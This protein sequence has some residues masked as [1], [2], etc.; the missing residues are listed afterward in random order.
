MT[1]A[2][3][4]EIDERYAKQCRR[5]YLTSRK[6][7]M[8]RLK[9]ECLSSDDDII[10]LTAVDLIVAI[11]GIQKKL[12]RLDRQQEGDITDEMVEQARKVDT[13]NYIDYER[14]R[15][16]AWCHDGRNPTALARLP[17]GRAYCHVC[18]KTWN[19]I[20]ILVERDG[21]SFPAAVKELC[22]L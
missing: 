21:Y 4:M 16:V 13:A 8:E 1:L 18:Q 20:D 10:L 11:N 7:E 19:S 2:A 14:G 6:I 9:D 15:A 17:D 12:D 3:R 22:Q 5:R